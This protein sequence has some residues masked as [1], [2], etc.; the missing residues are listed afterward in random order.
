MSK[1]GRYALGFFEF[2]GVEMDVGY[3]APTIANV[4]AILET[5]VYREAISIGGF[6]LFVDPLCAVDAICNLFDD[7]VAAG[8]FHVIDCLSD[9]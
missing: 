4:F 5:N 3:F 8:V 7:V 2:L 9:S 1:G 6:D